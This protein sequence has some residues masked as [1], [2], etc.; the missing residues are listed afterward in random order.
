MRMFELIKEVRDIV[1]DEAP[2]LLENPYSEDQLHEIVD[3]CVP[4]YNS[5]LADLLAEDLSLG[6]PEDNLWD[7]SGGNVFQVIMLRVYEV[8]MPEA[9]EEWATIRAE[10]EEESE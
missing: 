7:N 5:D 8:L 10:S 6:Y 1:R 9:E 4:I 3:G 2:E